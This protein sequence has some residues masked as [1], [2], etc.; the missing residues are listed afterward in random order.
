[1]DN[2]IS[3]KI[4]KDENEAY[5]SLP[6]ETLDFSKATAIQITDSVCPMRKG[7]DINDVDI[8]ALNN[9][10]VQLRQI[11]DIGKLPKLNAALSAS[12]CSSV[13]QA[14]LLAEHLEHFNL[15]AQI[16]NYAD[17]V[18]DE[19]ENIIGGRQAEE[20]R[21]CLDIEKYGRILQQGYNAEFTE[22]G[23]VT[24]DDFQP[25]DALWQNESEVMDMQIT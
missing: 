2:M 11:S 22:Y 12:Q 1:M 3:L 25:M 16:K 6:A 7:K 15:D 5:I 18:Y 20:L 17:L 14:I 13:D 24:R 4:T 8:S 10:A 23:M 21:Q 19:L 9:F